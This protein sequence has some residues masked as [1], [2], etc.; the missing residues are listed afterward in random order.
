MIDIKQAIVALASN[1]VDFVIIGGVA[2]ALHSAA[3]VTYDIDICFS[4]SKENIS[5]L[6][7]ALSPFEPRPRGLRK[8]LP[9]VWDAGT[10]SQGTIYT[11][12]TTIGDFDLLGEVE[13]FG[14]LPN[15]QRPGLYT[16]TE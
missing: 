11:L 13:G 7:G 3:Y 1:E 12:E 6:V 16:V 5:K 2:L 10:L 15:S 8:D 4:R 9:F 14:T